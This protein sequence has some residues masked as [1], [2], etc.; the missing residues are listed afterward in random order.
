V[1]FSGYGRSIVVLTLI[2]ALLSS[3]SMDPNVRKQKYFQH[4][5]D[6]FAKGKYQEAA[7]EFTNAIKIDAGY[8]D[9]HFQ[10]AE[11]CL[12]LQQGN[13]AYQE[14][15]RTVE[16]RPEDY[17]ARIELAN[18]LILGRKFQDA[19]AQADWLLKKRPDDPAVHVLA[20]NLLAVQGRIPDAI[21]EMQRGIALDPSRWEPHLS[22]ALLQ[23]KS[24][25][26]AAAEASFKKVIELNP[27][28]MQPHLALGEFYQSQKRF[29]E[30]EQ[31]FRSALAIDSTTIGPR[32]AL[33]RLYMAEG[34]KADAEE[35]LKQAVHDLPH[36]PD[37]FLAL[38][39]FYYVT[40]DLDK[41]VAEYHALFLERPK[42]L[43]VRKKYIELLLQA[44]RYDE[45]RSLNDEILKTNPKDYDALVYRSQMQINSGDVSDAEQTLQAVV[46]D[47]PNNIQA[48]YALGVAF[49]K[50]GNLAQAV[51]EWREALRLNPN[52]LDAERDIADAAMQQGDMNG[53]Q[54]AADQMIRLQP[55]SPEGYSLR[56]LAN[57]NG[58][59]YAEAE[60]DVRRAIAAAPQSSFGYVQMGN[61]RL[62]QKQY[63]DA[64]K[65]YQD[66]LDRSADST[67]A[68]RG[69][70][71]T[72]IAERQI[73]KAIAAA[74]AQIQKSPNNSRFYELLGSALVQG[75][76][77][78]SGGEA[79]FAK[80]AA[81]DKNNSDAAIHLCQV[82]AARGEVDQAIA[83]GEQSLKDNPRQPNLYV[84]MGN[85]YELKPDWKKAEGAFQ[86][87]LA[88]DSQ[89]AVASNDLARV[90]LQNGENLDVALA[91]AQKARTGLPTSPGVADTLGWIYYRKGVYPL[92][93][94]YLQEA[95]NQEEKNKMPENPDFDYHLGWAYEKAG[96]PALAR[97]HF[98]HLLKIRPNYPAAA[99]VKNE[100]SHLKV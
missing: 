52:F 48:H 18:L 70:M 26:F 20:A 81:L 82:R 51:G 28:A 66:A 94:T 60:Q 67:D 92:A 95:V 11:T 45:A 97:Q 3:C 4:G 91:L 36:N 31:E 49:R 69:L 32:E 87:S 29:G 17:K 90:M 5:Q 38:S 15:T 100:L 6:Y 37:S 83:T 77:D 33:A 19:Q 23:V 89:N 12:H 22:L 8:A 80:S 47:A 13:R 65:A 79:A 42:D 61:L 10:L 62:V 54:D 1:K 99:E 24:A 73:D 35:V 9:A 30:A 86:N 27:K 57:I 39:N 56:A 55:G 74:N 46:K 2:T 76:S 72:Y 43:V 64:A 34:K 84:V 58:K 75:K 88:I 7:I 78:L 59:H 14:L 85:L 96:Q 41:S 25:D 21:A 53:L 44:K 93:L 40:G 63:S 50:Q 71:N 68:L 98:E 16:L